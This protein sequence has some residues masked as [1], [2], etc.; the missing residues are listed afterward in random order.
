MNNLAILNS[1]NLEFQKNIYFKI[2]SHNYALPLANVLEVM[3]LPKLD[4]PQKLPSNFIGVLNFNNIILNVLDVR[5]YLDLEVEPYSVS[6]KL[7]IAKTDETMFGLVVDEINDIVDFENSKIERMPFVSENQIIESIYTINNE[8]VSILNAFALE[9]IIKNGYPDKGVNVCDLFPKDDI[10]TEVFEK[11]TAVL[12][13]RLD[14]TVTKNVFSDNKFLS[15]KLNETVYCVN[16]KYVKEVTNTVNMIKLPCSSDI[17]EGLMT[18]KGDF[19]TILNLKKFLKCVN[20]EYPAKTK[21]VIIDSNEFKLGLLIDE[22]ND[23]LDVAEDKLNNKDLNVEDT[24][25]EYEII[26]EKD[27]KLVLNMDKILSD[28]RL[29]IEEL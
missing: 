13:Q 21:V 6:S 19:I 27:V 5:F 18:V 12:A 2:G 22:I 15:F 23:I 10:S 14:L 17:I 3:K 7:I 16:L 29:Y 24:Y 1:S 4:Y 11:R 25:I 28:E 9:K 20:T 26:E 8:N